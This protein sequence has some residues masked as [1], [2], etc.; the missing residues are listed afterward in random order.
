MQLGERASRQIG[1]MAKLMRARTV[2]KS[3]P[4]ARLAYAWPFNLLVLILMNNQQHFIDCIAVAKQKMNK[5]HTL[6]D[7]SCFVDFQR[8]GHSKRLKRKFIYMLRKFNIIDHTFCFGCS[9]ALSLYFLLAWCVQFF[10]H[11]Y[12]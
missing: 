9:F 10:H 3:T 8:I 12:Y 7:R 4:K 11:H 6:S 5:W 2:H 1:K